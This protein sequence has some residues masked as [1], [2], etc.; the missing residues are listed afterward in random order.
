MALTAAQIVARAC[1]IAHCP[2]FTQQGGQYLNLALN[3]LCLHRNLK[4]LRQVESITVSSGSNGPFS[5]PANYLRTY[6]LFFTVNNFPYFLFPISQKDYDKLFKDPSIANYPY[7]YATDLTGQQT[8][9]P[10]QLF[11]F[12]QTTS[13]LAMTHRY[14]INMP[15]IATPESSATVPWF[16]DQDYLIQATAL[17]LMGEIDDERAKMWEKKCED[18]LRTHLIMEGDEQ[19]VVHDIGLDPRRFRINNK[20]RPIKLNP[21]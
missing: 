1:T 4:M 13:S 16:P 19:E 17:R 11:I 10:T 8:Q 9:A 6:D 14:M 15:D 12:P 20:I 5:L 21:Y 2:G 3:D 7:C 18:M